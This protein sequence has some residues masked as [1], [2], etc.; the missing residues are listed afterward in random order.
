MKNGNMFTRT[1]ID[2]PSAIIKEIDY[3]FIFDA[4][5]QG[6]EKI[7][8]RAW[9]DYHQLGDQTWLSTPWQVAPT[10]PLAATSDNKAIYIWSADGNIG[11]IEDLF[12]PAFEQDQANLTKLS[13]TFTDAHL[14]PHKETVA[15]QAKRKKNIMTIAG[16]KAKPGHGLH[17]ILK[18][19]KLVKLETLL[20]V[21]AVTD[22][23]TFIEV[24]L[25]LE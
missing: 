20:A 1:T 4:D 23:I 13:S 11:T 21:P 22:F 14:G 19:G 16:Q 7:R 5:D 12:Y 8:A 24:L 15:A 2:T 10:N 9:N 17:L 6:P 18:E 3:L 25:K